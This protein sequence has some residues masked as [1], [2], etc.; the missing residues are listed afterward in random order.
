MPVV[1]QHRRVAV[2]M[3]TTGARTSAQIAGA[4][5]R[6]DLRSVDPGAFDL[7]RL[8]QLGEPFADVDAA[9]DELRRVVAVT[10][11]PWLVSE[12]SEELFDLGAVLDADGS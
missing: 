8:D 2:E 4:L 10:S 11:S 9:L 6:L 5:A 1:A 3:S 7:H 12:V